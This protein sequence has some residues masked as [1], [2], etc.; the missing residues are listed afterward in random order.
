MEQMQTLYAHRFVLLMVIHRMIAAAAT[1]GGVVLLVLLGGVLG[2]AAG[3][4]TVLVFYSVLDWL[5]QIF[6]ACGMRC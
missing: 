4:G 2:I 1:Y 6:M 5:V 3:I